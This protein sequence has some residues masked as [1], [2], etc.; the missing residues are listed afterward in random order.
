MANCVVVL[1]DLH[2]GERYCTLTAPGKRG[3]NGHTGFTSSLPA[4]LD[5]LADLGHIQELVLLGDVFEIWRFPWGRVAD[6]AAPFLEAI[7][8]LPIERI[9][10]SFGNHDHPLLFYYEYLDSHRPDDAANETCDPAFLFEEFIAPL[11]PPEA[12]T[13]SSWFYPLTTRTIGPQRLILHHGH[14]LGYLP[15]SPQLAHLTRHRSPC[16]RWG[17]PEM[18][19]PWTYVFDSFRRR[20]MDRAERDR[21]HLRSE[22]WRRE[23]AGT[24]LPRALIRAGAPLPKPVS[25]LPD[26][27]AR[28]IEC[29]AKDA[30]KIARAGGVKFTVSPD[31]P[32]DRILFVFGHIH[33]SELWLAGDESDMSLLSIGSWVDEMGTGVQGLNSFAVVFDDRVELR[34]VEPPAVRLL[35]TIGL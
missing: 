7:A 29:Y 34:Q 35:A 12:R 5:F 28:S 2:F 10:F 8:R 15:F 16:N 6:A 24:P 18:E 3:S 9:S 13:R 21:I 4:L 17:I 23:I 25:W 27:P 19:R 1:S 30:R 33:H 32:I 20:E 11:I 26:M 14:Y 22:R 31:E